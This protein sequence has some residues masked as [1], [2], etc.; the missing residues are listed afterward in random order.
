MEEKINNVDKRTKVL[1][2]VIAVALY[3]IALNPWLCPVVVKTQSFGNLM[4]TN[5]YHVQHEFITP[6]L[7]GIQDQNKDF[8]E[9]YQIIIKTRVKLGLRT[10]LITNIYQVLPSL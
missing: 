2:A 4:P 1:L 8:S 6:T 10:G 7:N 5:I 3:M 9:T